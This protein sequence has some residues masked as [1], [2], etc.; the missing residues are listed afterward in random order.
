MDTQAQSA[1]EYEARIYY[2]QKQ[3]IEMD[4]L[5]ETIYYD[6]KEVVR[7]VKILSF[8]V[9]CLAIAIICVNFAIRG[10]S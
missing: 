6:C 8:A 9:F 2:L 10:A 5:I 3:V 1:I 7:H 4:G